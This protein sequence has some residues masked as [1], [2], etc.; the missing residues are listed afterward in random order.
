MNRPGLDEKTRF[1]IEA[2]QKAEIT[3]Y[4]I[5]L[6]L[7]AREKNP[8]NSPAISFGIGYFVRNWLGVD[9]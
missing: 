3:D 8:A 4:Q 2:F 5:Y 7:A 6:T 9:I 1:A